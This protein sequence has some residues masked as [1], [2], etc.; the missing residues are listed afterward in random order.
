[1]FVCSSILS[2]HSSV[3]PYTHHIRE[4]KTHRTIQFIRTSAVYQRLH[5][6]TPPKRESG[7]YRIF[8][9]CLS[10]INHPILLHYL[11]KFDCLVTFL[12]CLC[13]IFSCISLRAK[14]DSPNRFGAKRKKKCL[15][16]KNSYWKILIKGGGDK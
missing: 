15:W 8:I 7:I 13:S 11:E 9:V 12:R 5:T 14:M 10:Y 6:Y 3:R 4:I 1:M 16:L 2:V